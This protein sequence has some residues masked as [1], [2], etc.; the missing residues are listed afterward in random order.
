M[1]KGREKG[2]NGTAVKG[3]K[4]QTCSAYEKRNGSMVKKPWGIYNYL[5]AKPGGGI[6]TLKGI[7][8]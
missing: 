7:E 2:S 3:G 5:K 8:P 4:I 1:V 6:K